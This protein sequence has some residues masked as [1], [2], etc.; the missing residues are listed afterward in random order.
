MPGWAGGVVLLVDARGG[1]D[2]A[3]ERQL[4]G[5]G[6]GVRTVRDIDGAVESISSVEPDVVVLTTKRWSRKRACAAIAALRGAEFRLALLFAG[7]DG[8]P[9]AAAAV[10]DCGADDYVRLP[11]D[12]SELAARVR[13]LARRTVGQRPARELHGLAFDAR[14]GVLRAG[15]AEVVLTRRESD[16]FEYLTRSSGR[17]VS[18][19]ELAGAIWRSS[20]IDGTNVVDVYVSYLRRKLAAVGR[21]SMIRSVRGIGYCIRDEGG[22]RVDSGQPASGGSIS[23]FTTRREA[24]ASRA[25]P[26][27]SSG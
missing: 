6:F 17:V 9:A 7:C 1:H 15:D 25:S 4:A 26:A 20:A 14:H 13:A 18:R 11:C 19:A 21:A 12:A 23:A 3:L 16:V 5:D 24:T 2:A 22:D 8:S 27:R 10:L